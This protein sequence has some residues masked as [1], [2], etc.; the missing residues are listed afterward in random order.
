M[1]LFISLFSTGAVLGQESSSDS[2]SQDSEIIV[3]GARVRG[4][5]DV[6]QAPV[7]ELDEADIAALGATSIEEMLGAISA[8]TSSS[9][10]RGNGRPI[11]LVNG[12]RIGSFRELRSYPPEAI[13]KVEV[14]PEEVA[15]KFGFSPD[16]RVVNIILK[17]NYGSREIELEAES[18]DRGNYLATE[19]EFTLLRIRDGSRLNFNI[20]AENSDLLLEADRGVEQSPSRQSDLE[21]DPDPAQFR[22]LLP[23]SFDFSASLNWAKADIEAGSSKSANV[24]YDRAENRDLTGLNFV[25]LVSPDGSSAQRVFGGN[26]PLQR[27]SSSDT[28]AIAGSFARSLWGQQLTITFDGSIAENETQV[29]RVADVAPL[30][31]AAASGAMPIDAAL[32]DSTDA[33]FDVANSREWNVSSKSVLRG[34]LLN[35]P[36]GELSTTFDLGYSW[37]RIESDDTRSE[38]PAD[39]RRGELETGVNVAIPITSARQGVWDAL[40]SFTL[41]GQLGLEYLSDFG[42]LNDWSIGLNWAPTGNFNLQATRIFKEAAPS[43]TDLGSPQSATLNV[44]VFDFVRGETALATVILGGNSDLVAETQRDWKFSANWRLPFWNGTRLSADYVR[45]RSRNVT[46][47]LPALTAEIEDAFPDRFI[48]DASGQINTIDAR[49]ITYART[50]SERLSFGLITRGRWG[51]VSRDDAS[52]KGDPASNGRSPAPR[53]GGPRLPF[54]RD[55]RGNYFASL[56]HNVELENE[57]L[58]APGLPVLDLLNGDPSGENGL[59]RHTTQLEFG[60]FRNGMGLRISGRYTGKTRIN[61]SDIGGSGDVL[62]GDIAKLDLR[63]FVDL[64]RAFKRERGA[65]NRLRLSMRVRNLFDAQRRIVDQMGDVPL[66]YQ[67]F[68]VDPLG[69]TV[70]IDLRKMF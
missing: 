63:F 66:R 20:E 36:A 25:T 19:Q 24:T 10:G 57:V 27:R 50:K 5:L 29:D 30:I 64:G 1:L 17:E 16:R 46:S 21:S 7:V 12:I 67:P 60:A 6:P 51:R 41:N 33:G 37:N 35:M 69:R 4:S 42:T 38:I 13:L 58:I 55:G 14:L 3:E 9:R 11:T 47:S 22:S 23:D 56:T 45:N 62:F 53:R 48:R 34:V 39:L 54:G 40:G 44:P 59:P 2:F 68:L 52:A 8:Q 15:Q 65:L 26:T 70:R 32:P 18:P 61:G 31:D 49:P 43:L 28:L